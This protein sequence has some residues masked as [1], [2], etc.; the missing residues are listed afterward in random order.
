MFKDNP[1]LSVRTF[2]SHI[3]QAGTPEQARIRAA[4]EALT[5]VTSPYR[6]GVNW[7]HRSWNGPMPAATSAQQSQFLNWDGHIEPIQA[8]AADFLLA[9]HW[10]A[11]RDVLSHL[12]S[13]LADP[14]QEYQAQLARYEQGANP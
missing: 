7:Y 2:Y 11:S 3:A 13:R 10:L 4:D 6:D 12:G 5:G 1:A 8:K 14:Y 9:D